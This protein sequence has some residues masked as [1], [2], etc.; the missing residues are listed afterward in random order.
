MSKEHILNILKSLKKRPTSLE[1]RMINLV[2]K[3]NLP[4]KY[5]GDGS[6]IIGYKNPDFINVNG[7]K[8]CIEVYYS[9]QK[10]HFFG[11]ENN[12]KNQRK[13]HFA[14]YGWKTLF[15]NEN[16]LKETEILKRLN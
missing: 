16:Q 8:I 14:K 9:Y 4:Y 6:F 11:S 12:Y 7:E 2:E 13:E 15:F 10:N 5:T 1:K 3:H